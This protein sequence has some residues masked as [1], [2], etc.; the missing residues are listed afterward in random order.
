MSDK[1]T[2]APRQMPEDDERLR[3]KSSTPPT[4][5][6]MQADWGEETDSEGERDSDD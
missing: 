4:S 6:P 5:S 2:D 3:D 1:R